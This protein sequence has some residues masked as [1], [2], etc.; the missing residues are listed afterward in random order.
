ML[1]FVVALT[2]V[3]ACASTMHP[4]RRG[5]IREARFARIGGIDQWITIRGDDRANPVLLIMHGGPGDP[6]SP[7]PSWYAP[8]EHDFTVVQWDQPGAGK[9]YGK[10]PTVAPTPAR[11]IAD[12]IELTRYLE[13]ELG[14]QKLIVLGHSWG[15]FLA[16]GMVQRAPELYA[17]VVGTGQTG[18]FKESI[19]AQFD[20]LLE[21]ARAANDQRTV[22]K[23]EAIGKPDPTDA[24]TYFTWWRIVHNPY[25]A[26][27]D[28]QFFTTL[29]AT[30]DNDPELKRDQ[31]TVDK[32]MMFSGETTVGDMLTTDLPKT[33][34][35]LGVP[36]IVIQGAEDMIAPTSVA[37]RYFDVVQAPLKKWIEV[38][39]AGHFAIVT[40]AAQVRDALVQDVRSLAM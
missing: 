9:T 33:A 31:D 30:V 27:S 37:K 13:H 7:F 28:Q 24:H 39:N 3:T 5:P 22:A 35:Q 11:V 14:K 25:I 4:A 10:N 29:F 20:F 40:H 12:G 36:F 34:P 18:S 19:Q 26:A 16:I 8:Y 32:G 1:K 21:H 2:F 17:A 23:L 38:P 15:S 6:Q